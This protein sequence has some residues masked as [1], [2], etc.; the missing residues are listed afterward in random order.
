MLAEHLNRIVVF[1]N[2]GGTPQ[3]N[4]GVPRCWRNT[5]IELRC[6]KVLAEHLNPIEVF[7]SVGGTPQSSRNTSIQFVVFPT[8]CSRNT[9]IYFEIERACGA[10]LYAR[11]RRADLPSSLPFFLSYPN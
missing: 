11:L 3:S 9:K 8:G 1:Q 5:S 4:R 7:Q 2:V 6:S 10:Y